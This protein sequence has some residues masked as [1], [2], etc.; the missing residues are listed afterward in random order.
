MCVNIDICEVLE[1][2]RPLKLACEPRRT[3]GDPGGYIRSSNP[4]PRTQ[5]STSNGRQYHQPGI[6]VL[7]LCYFIRKLCLISTEDSSRLF[8]GGLVD[9]RGDGNQN[10]GHFVPR[11]CVIIAPPLSEMLVGVKALEVWPKFYGHGM[12]RNAWYYVRRCTHRLLQT[13]YNKCPPISLRKQASNTGDHALRRFKQSP[14]HKFWA[15]QSFV[16]TAG[17]H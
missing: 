17:A 3:S 4:H 7:W 6:I 10:P 1:S 12:M 5:L 15:T 16:S 8:L 11:R 9:G 13:S 2:S 14:N